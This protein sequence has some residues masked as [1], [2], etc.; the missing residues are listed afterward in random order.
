MGAQNYPTTEFECE[1]IHVLETDLPCAVEGILRVFLSVIFIMVIGAG[2]LLADNAHAAIRLVSPTGNDNPDCSITA[3]RHIQFAINQAAASDTVLVGAGTYPENITLKTGLH[4]LS[5]Q[6]ATIQGSSFLGAW[7]VQAVQTGPGTILE[8]FVI[9]CSDPSSCGGIFIQDGAAEVRRNDIRNNANLYIGGGIEVINSTV[10]IV[11]NLIRNNHSGN[12]GGGIAV[13]NSAGSVWIINNTFSGNLAGGP[14][15][16][17]GHI[18]LAQSG[19]VLVQNNI[20]AGFGGSAA[21]V[22]SG[23]TSP[24]AIKNNLFTAGPTYQDEGGIAGDVLALNNRS[25]ATD[26]VMGSEGKVFALPGTDFHLHPAGSPA[27][28][29]GLSENAPSN[30]FDG[31]ARPLGAGV[32]IGFDEIP[33]G[34][35]GMTQCSD[36]IDNDGDGL[37]DLADPGCSNSSDNDESNS[38]P[39]GTICSSTVSTVQGLQAEVNGISASPHAKQTLTNTLKSVNAALASGDRETARTQL[40]R[41]TR[42]TVRFSNLKGNPANRIPINQAGNLVCGAA[43]VLTGIALP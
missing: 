36:G 14:M 10:M 4:V 37:I 35:G 21:I 11:N 24:P 27:K 39:P 7:T 32:D 17:G 2:I 31:D 33:S 9:T 18:H 43:N 42:E 28:D 8:G 15:P 16:N 3:C 20:F 5:T 25:F 13:F 6:G 30:D 34:G 1:T 12:A 29:K 40:A 23:M 38:S 22:A 19:N 26:N 41:F